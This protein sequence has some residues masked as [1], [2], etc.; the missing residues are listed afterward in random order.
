VS[1]CKQFVSAKEVHDIRNDYSKFEETMYGSCTKS[2]NGKCRGVGPIIKEN[3]GK[4]TD[5][6][7][8]AA[9]RISLSQPGFFFAVLFIWSLT[10]CRELKLSLHLFLM[11]IFNMPTC[12]NM[13]QAIT[14]FDAEADEFRVVALPVWMKSFIGI[15]VILPR[16]GIALYLTWLGCRWLLAINNFA[17]LILNAVALEFVLC[18]KDSLFGALMSRKN[19]HDVQNTKFPPNIKKGSHAAVMLF[20][21][22]FAYVSV[23]FAWV[24]IYIGYLPFL[25]LRFTGLQKVLPGYQWDVHDVCIKWM[26]WRYCVDGNCP[27]SPVY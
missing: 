12:E 3:F 16:V 14:D 19:R 4:L 2:L 25:D 18:L 11:L 5:A 13:G 27:A 26:E 10:T 1:K 7:Q 20:T 8:A 23:T 9:C 17:D 22:T 6:E 15:V 21:T 24:A